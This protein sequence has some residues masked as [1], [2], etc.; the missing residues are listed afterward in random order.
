MQAAVIKRQMR[1]RPEYRGTVMVDINISYPQV[2]TKGSP[3]GA[4]ISGFYSESA[5]AYYTYATGSF[6]NTAVNEYINDRKSKI[7]FRTYTT[8]KIHEV[9]YN[10]N[11]FLSIFSDIYEFTGGAHG[12]TVRLADTWSLISGRR[13]QMGDF[14][15]NTTYQSILIGSIM[16][17]INNQLSKG[18]N[19]YFDDYQKNVF[20]Y[21]DE[22]NFYL[23]PEGLAV[24][25]PLYTI[26]PYSSGL[27][28]F[29][30]PYS[31]FVGLLNYQL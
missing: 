11:D 7:P 14:F 4:K 1:A 21:Y 6:Y 15:M 28:T 26:A 24:F 27:V 31:D 3:S 29:V 12:N 9:P 13:V 19:I 23:T 5:S 20:K 18:N 25:F 17:H 30:V 22:R 2:I 8:M 16:A 10:Q